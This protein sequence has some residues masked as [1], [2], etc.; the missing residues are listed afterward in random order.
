[1]TETKH[2]KNKIPVRITYG[3]LGAGSAPVWT[4]HEAGIFERN[5]LDAEVFMIRGR[6]A[7]SDALLKGEVHFG[8]VASP[9]P[10]QYSLQGDR[11]LVY[12]TGGL[13]Y[14]VQTLVVQPEITDISQLKGR[15]LGKSGG[16]SDLDDI[17]LAQF[18]PPAGIDPR[19]D[20]A[21]A[22]NEN[23]PD[24]IE[25]LKSGAIDGTLL[26]P[27]WL[28]VAQKAGF[29]II[30]DPM[31]VMIDYQLGGIVTTKE[32]VAAEPELVRRVVKSYVD[33]VHHYKRHPDFATDVVQKYSKLTDRD[34]AR[35]CQA[36]YVNF[37]GNKPYP[38][39]KG[40]Q[41]VLT[42]LAK[43]LPEAAGVDAARF[44]DASWLRELD[45][46]GYID[47]LYEREPV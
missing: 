5:G 39:D 43:R 40:I 33:G 37:F 47:E 32:L 26:T 11:D 44:I 1:M 17:L 16:D 34:I 6:A 35:Q 31:D 24:A 46:S 41:T 12:L 27:P 45:D 36:H 8:N 9:N 18:L 14:V 42:Q 10:L 29:K 30:M 2:D 3:A 28:F 7:V 13:N 23:Q 21:Y 38:S 25:Q 20:V 19:K 15:T 22:N 4:A